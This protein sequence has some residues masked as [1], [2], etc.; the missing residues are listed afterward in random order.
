MHFHSPPYS[1]P[2]AAGI[3]ALG[4]SGDAHGR[5]WQR[6]SAGGRVWVA[7]CEADG[8]SSS[9]LP[10]PSSLFSGGGEVNGVD[11]ESTTAMSGSGEV[12][13]GVRVVGSAT[14]V[15]MN[16]GGG[17]AHGG[18]R[19]VECTEVVAAVGCGW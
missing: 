9:P 11:D 3:L 18:H 19:R 13:T 8:L 17:V 7:A 16:G 12:V 14:G 1:S 10:H 15:H 2:A 6:W 4:A 5:G